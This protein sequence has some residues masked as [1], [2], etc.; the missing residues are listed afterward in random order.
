MESKISQPRPQLVAAIISPPT[1]A[2]HARAKAW[3]SPAI[4]KGNAPGSTTFT[5]SVR[6]SAPMALAARSQMRFT[7][8]MR[9]H[10]LRINGNAA[11]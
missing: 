4:T 3:R 8:R 6:S 5:K 7:D 1:T 10:A 9:V 2:I 11:A